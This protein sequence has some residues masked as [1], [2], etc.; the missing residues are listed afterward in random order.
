LTCQLDAGILGDQEA[1]LY[2]RSNLV[3][4]FARWL[5]YKRRLMGVTT[6]TSDRDR[7]MADT[8]MARSSDSRKALHSPE[9]NRKRA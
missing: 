4:S 8:R 7:V 6:S 2:A 5:E 9:P 1:L 3:I